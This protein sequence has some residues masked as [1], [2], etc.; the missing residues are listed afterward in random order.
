MSERASALRHYTSDELGL[1]SSI[2]IEALLLEIASEP[3][4]TDAD[5]VLYIAV[6]KPIRKNLRM[7]RRSESELNV[8]AV[9]SQ[10]LS[11]GVAVATAAEE[12]VDPAGVAPVL[13]QEAELEDEA[14]NGPCFTEE[15]YRGNG[16]RT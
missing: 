5:D 16:Q 10:G 12:P 11:P 1:L 4:P 6:T 9:N 13:G 8:T 7:K 3:R 2:G 15:K 14:V